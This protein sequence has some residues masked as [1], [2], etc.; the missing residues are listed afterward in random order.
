[1]RSSD[2]EF[3]DGLH[4][5]Q[6]HC[7]RLW[8]VP[9]NAAQ[10]A[11]LGVGP[12]PLAT[13]NDAL[14]GLD[15]LNRASPRQ[16]HL[17][18]NARREWRPPCAPPP[19]NDQEKQAM[20]SAERLLPQLG[21]CLCGAIRYE[22]TAEPLRVTICHCYFCQK[23]TGG[24]YMVEPIFNKM[25]FRVI[26]GKARTYSHRSTGS[27]QLIHMHSCP[28]CASH[29]YL[30][31]DRFE[32]LGVYAGSFDDPNWFPTDASIVRHIF[33]DSA[34]EDTVFPANVDIYP[35]HA[36]AYDG[37]PLKCVR[38]DAPST[39]AAIRARRVP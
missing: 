17:E 11:M 32:S 12:F 25:D 27:G 18:R 26:Q 19:S 29:L 22:T 31:F 6:L 37:S 38:I 7:F 14:R 30:T 16:C 2:N 8:V 1:M 9:T 5:Y 34:R 28:V 15:D 20:A 21:G 10:L 23:A 24:P 4:T 35:G 3:A 33:F 36:Q 13:L 39:A